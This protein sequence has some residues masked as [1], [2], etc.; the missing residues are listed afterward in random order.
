V[1]AAA[2]AEPIGT[3][4]TGGA[5]GRPLLA[6]T[7]ALAQVPTQWSGAGG[8]ASAEVAASTS[9]RSAKWAIHTDARVAWVF[10]RRFMGWFPSV[11][12]DQSFSGTILRWFA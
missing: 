6:A 9:K 7:G 11:K 5:A 10:E 2:G 12:K 8:A 4:V 3:A 1:G